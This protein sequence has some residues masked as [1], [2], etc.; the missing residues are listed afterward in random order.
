MIKNQE[1]KYRFTY[2]PINKITYVVESNKSGDFFKK[3]ILQ[4]K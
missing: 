3:I 1:K 4:N 2:F